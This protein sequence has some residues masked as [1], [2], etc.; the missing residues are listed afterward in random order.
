MLD[1]VWSCDGLGRY[2]LGA[3]GNVFLGLSELA[4]L[5][6]TEDKGLSS[7][8]S[9]SGLRAAQVSLTRITCTGMGTRAS[10]KRH[11]LI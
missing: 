6:G 2:L 5:V 7:G 1:S 10:D 9:G 11:F 3:H 4:L 8:G